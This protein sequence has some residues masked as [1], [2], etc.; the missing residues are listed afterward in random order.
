MATGRTYSGREFK[1]ILGLADNSGSGGAIGSAT[2]DANAVTGSKALMRVDSPL[3]DIAFD[4]GYNRSEIERAGSRALRAED[5]INHYGSGIWTWDF[6]YVADNEIAVQN[7]L[8]LIYPDNGA[9]TSALTI[10]ANPVVE[11]YTMGDATEAKDRSAFILL[12]N[13]NTD[14]DRYMHSAILQN[15]TMSMDIGTNGG[16][17]SFSGQFMSGYKPIIEANTVTADTTASDLAHSMFDFT[18]HTFGGSEV[19]V[20]SFDLTLENPASRVG[21]Q[22]TSGETD[23]Y[24]R[25]SKFNVTGNISFKADTTAQAFLESKWQTNTTV[26]IALNNGGAD[27]DISI[28]AA[29]ISAYSMD[30]ADEGTFINCSFTATSGADAG[31]NVAVIKIT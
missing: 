22:G 29:N 1:C 24:S 31:G 7:L 6:S 20:K 16:R 28:P 8:Q 30:M 11:Q 13:P 19:S 9:T 26:A 4:A 5:V 10:P 12:E 18:T 3:N 21:F 23:G 2:Q 14:K 17:P 15:L 27:W 25:G